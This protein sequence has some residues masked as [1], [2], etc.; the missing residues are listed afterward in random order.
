MNSN[1]QNGFNLVELMITIA[2][3]GVLAG[4]AIPN[5]QAFVRKV[6]VMSTVGQLT[7]IAKGIV[8]LRVVE[9]KILKDI[10]GSTCSRCQFAGLGEHYTEF[11]PPSTTTINRYNKAGMQ[12]F[13]RDAWGQ[14][15]ILNENELESDPCT[16]DS[17]G[18]LGNDGI[19]VYGASPN[20][21]VT[22]QS[23]EVL[24]PHKR[25]PDSCGNEVRTMRI[26][27]GPNVFWD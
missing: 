4:M 11:D 3:I 25:P 22:G 14:P 20:Y 5:Y 18:S 21:Y 7:A 1:N 15:I 6:R 19:Y 2:I 16:Q 23:F 13:Q 12:G 10:T 8:G 9:D 26:I 27:M 17:I 24:I